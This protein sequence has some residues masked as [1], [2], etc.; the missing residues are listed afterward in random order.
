MR[1]ARALLLGAVAVVAAAPGSARAEAYSDPRLGYSFNSPPK[2][3]QQATSSES[4]WLAA[5][6]ACNREYEWNDPKANFWTRHRPWLDVV[7]IPLSKEGRKGA[8]VEKTETGDIKITRNVPWRD[9]KE[10]LDET[11]KGIGGFHF[12]AESETTLNGLRVIQY[13]V[14]VDK[15]VQGERRVYGWA[16]YT[17]DAIYG[18]VA[19]ILLKEEDKLK[20]VIHQSFASFKAFPRKGSL[21]GTV[22]GEEILVKDPSKEKG[23]EKSEED[24][25]KERDD[26]FQR[27][28][29]KA[30]QNLPQGWI[31]LESKNFV[32][33]SHADARYTKDVLNHAEAFRGWLVKNLDFVGGGHAGR[34]LIRICAN[35]EEHSAF[36]QSRGWFRDAPEVVTYQDKSG[37]SDWSMESLNRGIFDIWMRDK[38]E[39]LLYSAPRWFGHGLVDVLEGARSKGG[40]IDFKTDDWEAMEIKETRRAGKLVKAKDFFRMTG[41]E[42]WGDQNGAW[43]QPRFFVRFLLLG[44]ASRHPK[45]KAVFP[46]Y[47]KNLIFLLDEMDAKQPNAGPEKEPQNEAEEAAMQRERA[48][49]WEKAEREVLDRLMEKTFE[50]WTDKDWENFNFLYEKDL[51]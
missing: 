34:V 36:Q 26:R 17:D 2:W 27:E 28:V 44:A 37:W 1:Y 29:A 12:S 43:H 21:P 33:V 7:V 38:N 20:P 46:D 39:D 35:S 10:Y 11:C 22:T 5:K 51:K 30:K 18:L 13:E 24:L 15:L 40:S 45:Y 48:Q 16:Y 49:R 32:A 31:T 8:T 25:K 9:L 4:G 3:N 23:V 50:G 42:L 14:T 6:F 19:E 47:I 41:N